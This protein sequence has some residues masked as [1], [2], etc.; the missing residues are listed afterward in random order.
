[1]IKLENCKEKQ[2]IIETK[3]ICNIINNIINIYNNNI[4]R[5]N[6]NNK[7]ECLGKFFRCMYATYIHLFFSFTPF[8]KFPIYKSFG[9][10]IYNILYY[11]TINIPICMTHTKKRVYVSYIRMYDTYTF[12][13]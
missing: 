12:P 8:P 3:Y 1:M 4:I 2:I 7:K 6:I 9:K 13:I 11:Y 10:L 5:R